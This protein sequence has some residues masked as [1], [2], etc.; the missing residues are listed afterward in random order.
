MLLPLVISAAVATLFTIV[1]LPLALARRT[2]RGSISVLLF[3][4]LVAGV[5]AVCSTVSLASWLGWPI[6]SLFVAGLVALAVL[7]IREAG[8]LRLEDL[9]PRWSPWI[10]A[11]GVLVAVVLA[12]RLRVVEF[13]P[14]TG[15]MGNYVNAANRWARTGDLALGFPPG[16]AVFLGVPSKL[17]GNEA[18][19]ASVPL[20]GAILVGSLLRTFGQLSLRPVAR[21]FGIVLIGFSTLAIWYSSFPVSE[22][23]QAPLTV[24]LVSAA[25][26]VLASGGSGRI[27]GI[28]ELTGAML[29][30]LTL[31]LTRGTGP[32]LLL[33]LLLLLVACVHPRWRH[34]AGRV[35]LLI[36]ASLIG[37]AISYVYGVE[38]IRGYYVDLQIRELLPARVFSGL[39]KLGFF[40]QSPQLLSAFVALGVLVWLAGRWLAG[41]APEQPEGDELRPDRLRWPLPLTAAIGVAMGVVLWSEGAG[42]IWSQVNRLGVVLPACGLLG[43]FVV[44]RRAA[45]G[46]AAVLAGSTAG[47]MLVVQTM[48]FDTYRAHT[49]FLY[50]DRYLF[51][52]V[53]PMFVLLAAVAAGGLLGWAATMAER[54]P[55]GGRSAWPVRQA[56]RIAGV[57][58]LALAVTFA[59]SQV[60]GISVLSETS[61]LAGT[62]DFLDRVT[63]L[64]E[65]EERPVLWT[66]PGSGPDG[67]EIFPNSWHAFGKPVSVT[68]GRDV[69]N[70]DGANGPFAPDPVLDQDAIEAL[71]ACTDEGSAY[72]VEFSRE[73]G[74]LDERLADDSA[75]RVQELGTA[76]ATLP[77][78]RHLDTKAWIEMPVRADVWSVEAPPSELPACTDAPPG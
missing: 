61:S 26:A 40:E 15:D 14:W 27:P 5:L 7:G 8:P 52:E 55:D 65:D 43:L 60:S 71:L 67:W 23:L 53:L 29:V 37:F 33:P 45:G 41:R 54:R 12:L 18:T 56:P 68:Y 11:A 57:V 62:T 74:D 66:G 13:L 24:L 36:P 44:H 9:R 2:S 34:L 21:L 64:L 16:F 48:R 3:D 49:Y 76:T 20:L 31:G 58:L 47:L 35:G 50:W 4:A 32:L 75:L 25:L 46:V 70:L 42:E 10:V 1:G 59:G 6:T 30:A 38:R 78:L 39:N 22:S 63:D 77:L 19:T 51:S 72:V 17:F 69:R 73:G 28:G